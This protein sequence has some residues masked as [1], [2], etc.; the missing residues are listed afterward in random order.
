L[1]ARLGALPGVEL[2]PV[3]TPTNMVFLRH[4]GSPAELTA[5]RLAE[6]GVLV[7]PVGAD[8]VRFVVHRHH[9]DA[10]IEAVCERAAHAFQPAKEVSHVG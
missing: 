3:S 9:T 8:V 4:A 1:R 10:D 7:L 2:V 5:S 6:S